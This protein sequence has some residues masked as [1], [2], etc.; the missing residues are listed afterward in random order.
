[1]QVEDVCKVAQVALHHGRVDLEPHA[2]GRRHFYRIQCGPPGTWDVA[3]LVVDFGRRPVH[4]DG[5]DLHA[6]ISHE[7]ELLPG[8]QRRD[9]R[10][11]RRVDTL[12]LCMTEQVEDVGAHEGVPAGQQKR[13][14]RLSELQELVDQPDPRLMIKLSR[15]TVADCGGP[16]VPAGEQAGFRGFPADKYRFRG[17]VHDLRPWRLHLRMPLSSETLWSE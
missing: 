10:C 14:I 12:V 2:A 6:E 11:H 9:A 5:D 13:G 7:L 1:G 4:A 16:A 15:E 8:Q 17:I 3:Y